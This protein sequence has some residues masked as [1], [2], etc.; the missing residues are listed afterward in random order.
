MLNLVFFFSSNVSASIRSEIERVL[1]VGT[2]NSM[3][4]Y[5]GLPCMVGRNKKHA[6]TGIR[7]KIRSRIIAWSTRLLLVG[8]REV[9]IKSVLQAIPTFA[10]MCF[11]LPRSFCNEIEGIL[12]KFWWQRGADKRGIHWCCWARLSQLKEDSGMGFR[13]LAKFNVA[14]LAK[15]G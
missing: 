15:Q 2:A 14:L 9:F 5:L 4:R 11:L 3:E 1:G 13:D 6:F 8:G 10:M 7:D 12:A